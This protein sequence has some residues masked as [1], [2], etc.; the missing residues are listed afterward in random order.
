MSL[1]EGRGQLLQAPQ[2]TLKILVL[3][4]LGNHERILGRHCVFEISF[5]AIWRI[6]CR[7]GKNRSTRSS[8]EVVVIIQVGGSGSLV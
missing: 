2:S 1:E 5:F 7:G 8:L 4:A 3:S 6:D